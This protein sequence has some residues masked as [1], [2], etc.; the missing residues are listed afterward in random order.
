MG[1]AYLV[2]LRFADLAA[3]LSR[4]ARTRALT[5]ARG[6]MNPHQRV[7]DET[8]EGMVRAIAQLPRAEGDLG[9]E[10]GLVGPWLRRMMDGW[11]RQDGQLGLSGDALWLLPA[12]MRAAL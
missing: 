12:A 2:H 3:G 9:L 11:A 8:F 7:E 6:D 5:F 4:L 10:G 1:A